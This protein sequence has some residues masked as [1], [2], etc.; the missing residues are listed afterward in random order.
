MQLYLTANPACPMCGQALSPQS[1]SFSHEP[2]G[3][4]K[5]LQLERTAEDQDI[6]S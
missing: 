5:K 2:L 1:L 6:D 4:Y 3:P